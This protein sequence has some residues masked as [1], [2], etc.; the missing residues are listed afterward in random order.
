MREIDEQKT[1]RKEPIMSK[2]VA[3]ASINNVKEIRAI[4]GTKASV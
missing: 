4:L 2:T 1:T 3:M